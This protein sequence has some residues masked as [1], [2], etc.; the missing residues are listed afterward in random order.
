[1]AKAETTIWPDEQ[2]AVMRGVVYFLKN[3][4]SGRVKIGFSEQHRVRMTTLQGASPDDLSL[5]GVLPGTMKSEKRLQRRFA[6][7]KIRGEWYRVE[8]ELAKFIK[9]LPKISKS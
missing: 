7:Y 3:G 2:T 8:G 6:K 1:M 4:A 9:T 5:I